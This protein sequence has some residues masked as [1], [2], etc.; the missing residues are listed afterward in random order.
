MRMF[1]RLS[2]YI[3]AISLSAALIAGPLTMIAAPALADQ[4]EVLSAQAKVELAE[5]TGEEDVVGVETP[6][7][8]AIIATLVNFFIFAFIVA[9][10]GG[11]AFNRAMA[12]RRENLLNEMEEAVRLRKEA[13]AE[14][15]VYLEKLEA[16]DRERDELMEEFRSI[17]ETERAQLIAEAEAEAARIVSDA[18]RMGEREESQAERGIEGRLVDRA[19]ELA[20]AEIERQVNPMVQNRLVDRSIDS[21]KS[22][23]AS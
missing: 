8:V 7:T 16:F 21:F 11:P 5:A 4:G 19:M 3:T 12:E 13:E 23:K 22:L 9:K 6:S 2:R 15:A 20:A 14:L 10:F 17:G 1:R 18:E